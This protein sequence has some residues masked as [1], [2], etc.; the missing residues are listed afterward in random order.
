MMYIYI[1]I[2]NSNWVEYIVVPS[3]FCELHTK[4]HSVITQ[5]TS[6]IL[7]LLSQTLTQLALNYN[8]NRL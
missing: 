6:I 7:T 2:Y 1:H 5:G 8:T 3:T 4:T